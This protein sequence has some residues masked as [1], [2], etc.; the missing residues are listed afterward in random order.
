MDE[1]LI[2]DLNWRK[3]I[4]VLK[5][6]AKNEAEN[7]KF[8]II[9]TANMIEWG[10]I[11]IVRSCGTISWLCKDEVVHWSRELLKILCQ[12]WDGILLWKYLS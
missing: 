12:I 4:L 3:A 7:S 6:G 10:I 5:K 2:I 9:E 1:K 11:L 8:E